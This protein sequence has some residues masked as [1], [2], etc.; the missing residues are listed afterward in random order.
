MGRGAA[1]GRPSSN[2][3][4]ERRERK[5]GSRRVAAA[6]PGHSPAGLGSR[7]PDLLRVCGPRSF[8]TGDDSVHPTRRAQGRRRGRARRGPRAPAGSQ[9]EGLLQ[10][11]AWEWHPPW[12]WQTWGRHHGGAQ[13]WQGWGEGRRG[14]TGHSAAK[15]EVPARARA[16]RS[17]PTLRSGQPSAGEILP[18]HFLTSCPLAMGRSCPRQSPCTISIHG[19]SRA[20]ALAPIAAARG[21][22]AGRLRGP[23]PLTSKQMF[24]PSLSQSSHSTMQSQPLPS[25]CTETRGVH[26]PAHPSLPGTEC[27]APSP[28]DC[29]QEAWSPGQ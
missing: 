19:I 25:T 8:L 21:V 3:R 10:R 23:Q 17:E 2:R 14:M 4:K 28:P 6:A 5:Q 11:E 15:A 29:P 9:P 16:R 7:S 13:S 1:S 22:Q 12:G 24:S 26:C 18:Q 20:G 27:A